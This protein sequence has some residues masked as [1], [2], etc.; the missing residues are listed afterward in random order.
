MA[1]ILGKSDLSV[2][3]TQL[4]ITEYLLV[5]PVSRFAESLRLLRLHLRIT[6]K[7]GPKIIQLT[8]AV[9]GEGKS[10][11]AASMAISAA[12]A[13]VRT[14]IVDLDFHRPSIGK[15]F[16]GQQS[17]GVFDIL[18]GTSPK[19]AALARHETL[20]L[21]IIDAGSVGEPRT[22][23]IESAKLRTLIE[24]LQQQFDLVILDSPPIL[25]ISD[26]L[27]ISGIVDATI[28]VVAWGSTPQKLVDEALG[29]LRA[30]NAPVAGLLLNKA[31]FAKA[32]KYGVG[33]Y[34]YAGYG[35]AA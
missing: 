5:K 23:M 35:T 32:G 29:A 26:P 10:T 17:R 28:M 6:G 3:S 16:S 33:Y 24:D 20:P 2:G 9:P 11:M 1:P 8:S 14:V 13:G 22:G 34:V 12:V 4:T 25:A 27:F 21:C 31:N 30:S 15:I 19:D 18:L 7:G